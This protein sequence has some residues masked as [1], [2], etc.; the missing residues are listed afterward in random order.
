[1]SISEKL[2]AEILVKCGR[3][4]CI[5]R[6]FA[7]LH[8]QVHHIVP[9]SQ[10]GSD[11]PENLIAVCVTCH[12][13]IHAEPGFGRRFSHTELKAHRDEV[14]RLVANGTLQQSGCRDD[15][16]ALVDDLLSNLGAR[17]PYPAPKPNLSAQSVDLL[18]K[19]VQSNGLVYDMSENLHM[20][21]TS[22]DARKAAGCKFALNQI[23][24]AGLVDYVSGLAYR[25]SH[26]GF[27][28]ADALLAA[29][30][31]LSREELGE[32]GGGDC[33]GTS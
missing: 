26:K 14:Y 4:C 15:L 8:L 9:V 17:S 7:P 32:E 31:Q 6:R 5:C 22:E 10:G 23:I 19:A 11:E 30:A 24:E 3:R 13:D 16:S 1:M 21:S 29:Q 18:L 28:L 2:T 33:P 25:V 12:S 20:G 27:M